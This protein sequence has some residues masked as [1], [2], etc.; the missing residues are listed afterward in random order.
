MKRII[1]T[2]LTVFGAFV[3][4]VAIPQVAPSTLPPSTVWGRLGI[5]A[6]PG[7]AIPFSILNAN[8]FSSLCTTAGAFPVY[9][10]STALWQCSTATNAAAVVAKNNTTH[11][12]T[13]TH[14]DAT[15]SSFDTTPIAA[16]RILTPPTATTRNFVSGIW[17]TT[18]ANAVDKGRGIAIQN[19][20]ASDGLYIQNDGASA[21]GF[22]SLL[23]ATATSATGGVIGTTLSSQVGLVIRQETSI[24]PTAASAT[25]LQI[26]AN[27][28]VTEMGRINSTVAAQAGLVFRMS[29]S[30]ASPII[31]K[32]ASDATVF[33][34]NNAGYVQLGLSGTLGQLAFGNAT[35]GLVTL[36]PVAGA[37][38]TVTLSLPA[39]T[40]TL[41]GRATTDTMTNKTIDGPS[42][43]VNGGYPTFV[44][45]KATGINFNSANTDTVIPINL[46]TGFTR[47]S[48]NRVMIAHASGTLTTSTF[49]VFTAAAGGG[50]A[51]VASG[52]ANTISTASEGTNNN[53]MLNSASNTTSYLL[54]SVPNIYFRVQTAQ[55]SAA[56]ADLI[57]AITP[58]P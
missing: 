8:F 19:L 47:F 33:Q 24:L 57:V 9:N 45:Y 36:Q 38:G 2:F 18:Q 6:G 25:L 44:S 27:G 23:T 31:I 11:A 41:V 43:T 14:P 53:T 21:T 42:I 13:L 4:A 20:G 5:S 55:G 32:N 3:A 7:Q 28:S 51:I 56:T 26:D 52:T 48:V 1:G 37:L 17:V 16:L 54:A 58:L 15:D 39:A 12:L 10:S 34:A 35:S 46:P 30:G 22:A 50:T 40:D 49:G 29:G